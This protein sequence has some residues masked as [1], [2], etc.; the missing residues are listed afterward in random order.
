MLKF[1]IKIIIAL[2]IISI[3]NFWFAFDLWTSSTDN[4][5]IS[6]ENT[7]K[8]MN[9]DEFE[10]MQWNEFFYVWTTWEKWIKYLLFNI[11]RDLRVIV[12]AFVLLF[13]VIMVIKLIFGENTE[14]EAKKLKNGILWASIWIIVMQIA[15]SIYK[16]MFD[17]DIWANLARSFWERLVEPFLDLLMLLASFAFIAVAVIAFYKIVTAWGNEE[18]LKKWKA[19]IFQAIIW[20]IVIK[21]ADIVVKNTY[22][23]DC[24]WGGL[25]SYW[26][27]SVCENITKNAKIITTFIN[28]L[29]TFIAIFI[30]VMLI[31]AGFLVMTWWWDEEKNKKAKKTMV[32]IWVWLLVLFASYAIMTFFIIP[33]SRI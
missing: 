21:F 8:S 20:F 26:W 22:N 18:W 29:N 10:E 25:I 32:Y 1:L 24:W 16:V 31:Y 23:P 5:R 12:Y 2:S 7:W 9:N 6:T 19:T 4:I 33:E 11:A 28:W 14:E 27:T 30:V 13:W 3:P 17:R 15:F